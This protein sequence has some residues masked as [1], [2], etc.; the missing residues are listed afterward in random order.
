MSDIDLSRVHLIGIGGAGILLSRGKVV[1]GSDVKESRPVL[2]LQSMGAHVTVGHKAENLTLSGQL[3][4]VVV[5]SFAAIPQDN[6]ELVA[7]RE[8]NIPVIRRSDLLGELMTGSTQVLIAGTHGKTSTTSMAVVAMQAAGMDP[9]FAI[10]GQLNKA[11]TN[12]HQGSGHCFVAEADESDASLLRY[13]PD[14]AVV[15]NIEPD[16][17]DFFHTPEAYFQVFDDFAA[18]LTDT[19]VLVVCLDDEHAA[20]L[21]ERQKTK[22]TVRGYGSAAAAERHPD[23]AYTVVESVAVADQISH[24]HMRVGEREVEVAMQIP[25]THMVLN[26]AA[27]LTAGVLAGGDVAALAQGISEFSGVRRRFEFH[28]AVAGGDYRGVEVYDDYAHHPTEVRAVL[29]AAREK[30]AARGSGQVIVV[31]QPHMYSRTQE[32]AA[33]FAEALSL[34]D[35]AVVLDIYGAR[36]QPH[37]G[38][39]SQL[40][41]DRMTNKVVHQ[42]NPPPVPQTVAELA[43]PGDMVIT[44]GA[45]DVTVLADEILFQLRTDD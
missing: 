13:S 41:I 30:L 24:A 27:A 2:A 22:V 7:A 3:P 45:G 21:G 26:A 44:M 14:I 9:S 39:T 42:P 16:H 38:I 19:G 34:A 17:L 8:H 31:F 12:A 5:T 40:I 23:I 37:D 10:G 29:T 4:T 35:A 28:G 33:E 32:F 36:E 18:R 43:H 20:A 1:S 6:P 25:G 15:T 11:G